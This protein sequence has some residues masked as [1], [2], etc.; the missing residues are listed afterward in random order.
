MIYRVRCLVVAIAK[1]KHTESMI[2]AAR[3]SGNGVFPCWLEWRH[4]VKSWT[5]V[6]KTCRT[7]EIWI[8][9]GSMDCQATSQVESAPQED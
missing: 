4:G 2:A 6:E 7:V 3:A 1:S 9:T 5:Y 8:E